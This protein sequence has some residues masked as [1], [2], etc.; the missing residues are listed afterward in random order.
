MNGLPVELLTLIFELCGPVEELTWVCRHWRNAALGC[1][2]LWTRIAVDCS[3]KTL[4]YLERSEKLPLAIYVN[5]D[6]RKRTRSRLVNMREGLQLVFANSSH[7]VREIYVDLD[8]V[9]CRDDTPRED[10]APQSA[11]LFDG[12]VHGVQEIMTKSD[13]TSAAASPAHVGSGSPFE[14][15]EHSAVDALGSHASER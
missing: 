2:Q 10:G 5:M 1:L 4:A 8:C 3:R 6:N 15:L 12:P 7:R 9:S 11:A 13:L 14:C